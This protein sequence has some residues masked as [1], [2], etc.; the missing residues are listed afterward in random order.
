MYKKAQLRFG[1]VN[2]TACRRKKGQNLYPRNSCKKEMK[3][4]EKLPNHK[5]LFPPECDS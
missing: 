4:Y 5:S 1:K 3:G 2:K